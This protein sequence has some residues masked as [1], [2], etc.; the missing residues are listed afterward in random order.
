MCG[1]SGYITTKKYAEFA[2][3]KL[4]SILLA[5]QGRGTDA[6]GFS[7][8]ISKNH[9]HIFKSNQDALK[10]TA[11]PAYAR[12]FKKHNPTIV[13]AHNRLQ[14]QG[15]AKNNKNNH[16]IEAIKTGLQLVHNGTI[17]NDDSV[18]EDF[19]LKRN[20][21]VDSEAIIALLNYY[22]LRK[23]KT[24]K[25]IQLASRQLRGSMTIALLNASEPKTLYLVASDNPLW[26]AYH[27]PTGTIFFA[28]T[29]E[30]LEKG[31]SNYDTYH[32]GFFVVRSGLS[33]Y[34]F[35]EAEDNTGYKLTPRSWD[36]FDIKRL[37]W[38][39]DNSTMTKYSGGHSSEEHTERGSTTFS[40]KPSEYE[41]E[42]DERIKEAIETFEEFD[43]AKNISKPSEYP[44]EILLYRLEYL[45]DLFSSGDIDFH[46]GKDYT[47]IQAHSEVN[48]LIC[49]LQ[50]R[51]KITKREIYIPKVKEIITKPLNGRRLRKLK[52][53]L[54]DKNYELLDNFGKFK[55]EMSLVNNKEKEFPFD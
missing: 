46:T 16:P 7:F 40:S 24:T 13:I 33:D 53:V 27:R 42:G 50:D 22:K 45:Q 30:M 34:V 39:N 29:E 41:Q 2:Y 4:T 32:K 18:F 5:G 1:I 26:F 51:K 15:K 43:I 35:K 17:N 3:T 38:A 49:A 37:T 25:A 54:I 9:Y 6:T 52:Y 8:N 23:F 11:S 28:S 36:T 21:E 44:S 12:A 47:V 48:R 31:L 10:F 55:A 19:K 14:T 20:A